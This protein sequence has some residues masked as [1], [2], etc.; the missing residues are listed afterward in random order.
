MPV[1]AGSWLSSSVNASSPPAEAPIPTIGNELPG[2]RSTADAPLTPTAETVLRADSAAFLRVSAAWSWEGRSGA[3][4]EP[5]VLRG[6]RLPAFFVATHHQCLSRVSETKLLHRTTSTLTAN[7]AFPVL[8]ILAG[9]RAFHVSPKLA[10]VR[11]C[12]PR[13]LWLRQLRLLVEGTG[14]YGGPRRGARFTRDCVD[15]TSRDAPPRGDALGAAARIH[16]AATVQS[17]THQPPSHS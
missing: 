17:L 3:C 16:G 7:L 2:A 11:H 6:A 10:H 5:K 9:R 13:I 15:L 8:P 14:D 12:R 4:G 1:S